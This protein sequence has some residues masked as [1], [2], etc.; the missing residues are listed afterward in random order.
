MFMG[1]HC[2][3]YRTP[4]A[5]GISPRDHL[6]PTTP[7]GC[8]TSSTRCG[9]RA[10]SDPGTCQSRPN[11]RATARSL[12]RQANLYG[13]IWSLETEILTMGVLG[14]PSYP[15]PSSTDRLFPDCHV[16]GFL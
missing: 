10:R 9:V 13:F 16:P 12:R 1:R 15:R 6:D 14:P 2:S 11:A 3:G 8:F 5:G 4:E 7:T